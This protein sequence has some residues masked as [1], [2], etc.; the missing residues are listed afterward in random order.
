MR[1]S[2]IL[3]AGAVVIAGGA[4]LLGG[5]EGPSAEVHGARL[6]PCGDGG[7]CGQ[8][9]PQGADAHPGATIPIG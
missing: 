4:A 2:H 7:R 5:R 6:G 9:A 8:P 1:R 3:L